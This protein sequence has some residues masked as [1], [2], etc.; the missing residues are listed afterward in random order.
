MKIKLAPDKITAY[1]ITFFTLASL[2]SAL[3]FKAEYV[4]WFAVAVL[5]ISAALILSLVKKSSILSHHKRSVIII[6]LVSD[7]IYLS[8]Y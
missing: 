3:A 6:M 2:L 1:A 5:L 7:L 4:K 8:L